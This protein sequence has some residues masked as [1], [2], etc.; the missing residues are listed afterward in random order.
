MTD[1]EEKRTQFGTSAGLGEMECNVVVTSPGREGAEDLVRMD[2]PSRHTATVAE[3]G[4]PGR[5]YDDRE[6]LWPLGCPP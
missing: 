4:L 2:I 3:E 1:E 6:G 5:L